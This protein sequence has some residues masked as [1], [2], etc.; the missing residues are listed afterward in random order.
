MSEQRFVRFFFWEE[1]YYCLEATD[2]KHDQK[3]ATT[4]DPPIESHNICCP[5]SS[6]HRWPHNSP[7]A[8]PLRF[9]LKHSAG[10]LSMHHHSMIPF[11]VTLYHLV[12]EG[13]ATPKT[14]EKRIW[15]REL[16]KFSKCNYLEFC[17][18]INDCCTICFNQVTTIHVT[19]IYM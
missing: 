2:M 13:V 15:S 9:D 5:F 12:D 14:F 7:I 10:D 16:S 19:T 4:K 18:T 11:V 1:E 3:L 6:S 17:R 8:G